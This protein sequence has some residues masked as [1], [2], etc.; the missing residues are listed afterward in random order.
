MDDFVH[1]MAADDHDLDEEHDHDSDDLEHAAEHAKH[2]ALKR[3]A[4]EF[5]RNMQ[6]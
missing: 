6:A 1:K 5:L 3:V 2:D 4:K